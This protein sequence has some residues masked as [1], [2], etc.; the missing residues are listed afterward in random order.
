MTKIG[1]STSSR[2][3]RKQQDRAQLKPQD[4]TLGLSVVHPQAA[5][6]DVGNA[7]HY[8]AIPPHLDA[9]PVRMFG[10]FTADLHRLAD[11]LQQRG[12][13]TA[14]MQS[15]GVY[16]IA[17]YDI[18][19]ERG[20][21][22]FLVNARDTKNMPGR[23]TDVQECQW[24]LKL[25]VYGL[26]KNSFRPEEEICVMRSLWRQR[27]QHIG[28]ASRRIQHM[29]KALTQMNVQ[30]ANVIGDLSGWT[31]QAILRAILKGERDPRELAKLRD[32]RVKASAE[33]IAKSLEGNWRM[34]LLFILRQEYDSYQSLQRQIQEC[35][36]ELQKHFQ[37]MRQKADP[38]QLEPVARNKRPHGNVPEN[39]DLRDEL[40]R[41]T[42][43]D[44]IQIDGM[45]VRT[46]QTVIAECG[47]DMSRWETE[48]HFVSPRNKISGGKVIG[49][50][51]RKVVNRAGQALRTAACTL[52]R[53]GSYLGAQYRRLRAKLGAPKA[54]K[55]MANKLARI[56]YRLLKHGQSYVDKGAEC[57][58]QKYRQ[59][60]IQMLTKRATSLGLQLIQS[61]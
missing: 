10:C 14:A 4:R 24:L 58:E 40:Y 42:G 52:L 7:E 20:I 11:W 35:D 23:K 8:V 13:E 21:K 43:V 25:H 32:A 30:L 3:G 17:L 5:G 44:L 54:I 22:V 28:D 56:L 45:N 9:E 37:T 41:I 49:R 50:E 31:G 29:Q 53:S 15:T 57:Y 2:R 47:Y 38:E 61:A 19:S 46:A 16:W 48:G 36:Q 12:I 51:G 55:A 33:Q 18:L 27:Q 34:E 39:L 59:Q 60:Q 1:K 26:L 6:I